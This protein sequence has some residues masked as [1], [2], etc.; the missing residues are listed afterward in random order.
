M[1]DR[2]VLAVLIGATGATAW[3]AE[4]PNVLLICVDDLKPLLGCYGDQTVHTPHLDRLAKRGMRFDLAYCNQAVCAPSRHALMTGLRPQTLGIYDLSTR[5]RTVAPQAVTWSQHFMAHDYRAEHLG[6]IYH[7]GHGN[8]D[9]QASWSVPGWKVTNAGVKLYHDPASVAKNANTNGAAYESADVVDEAYVDGAMVGVARDRLVALKALGKPWFLG[10]GFIRPHLPFVAPK[11]FWDL[12]HR[13]AFAVPTRAAPIAAPAYATQSGGEL[14]RYM[15]I[16]PQGPLDDDLTRTLIHGYH[17]AISYAD[18]QIGKVLDAL[19]AS[20][21]ATNTVIILWGDH[22]WHLGDHGQWC[23]HTNYEQATRIPLII[24]GPGIPAGSTTMALIETVDLYP[25]LAA[26]C[27][28]PLPTGL[29]GLDQGAVLRGGA[30]IRD[31]VIHVYPRGERLGRAIRTTRHRLV[32]WKKPGDPPAS[33]DL[34][35]YDYR[36]DPLETRN[37]AAQQPEVVA[38]LRAILGRHPEARA[39]AGVK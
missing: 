29:D 34:E 37:L 5:F 38:E 26:W 21:Q 7:L 3:G 13:D 8:G 12:Y 25:T 32:E 36:D 39:Q 20:G 6:K 19:D 27:G 24:A 18:A 31:H 33:A 17:A 1:I 28:L 23:K 11:R 2:L 15:G 4:H 10:V 16:P 30:A 22:G 14:R 9:D 35:L